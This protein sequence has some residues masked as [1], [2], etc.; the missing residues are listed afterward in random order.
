[1]KKWTR[2][3]ALMGA[4]LVLWASSAFA[5]PFTLSQSQLA[6]FSLIAV[7]PNSSGGTDLSNA[8]L[9]TG[10]Q[11]TVNVKSTSTPA[12][13]AYLDLGLTGSFDLTPYD[14]FSLEFKNTN[15]STWSVSLFA[16]NERTAWMPLLVGETQTLKLDLSSVAS[17]NFTTIGIG[18][19]GMMNNI[20]PN[21]SNPDYIHMAVAPVP[22]P[23]TL[24]LL[25]SGLVGVAW[26]ARRR[27]KE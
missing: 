15:N 16:D 7:G 10:V 20:L 18:L 2:V 23:G 13:F 6:N 24:L 22:E 27:K 25:G 11:Y 1:M 21:P 3:S 26:F 4:F 14:S 8:L 12:S 19:G 17:K 5:I 9:G